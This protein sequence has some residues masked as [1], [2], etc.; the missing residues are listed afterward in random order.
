MQQR[1]FLNNIASIRKGPVPDKV[2]EK[3]EEFKAVS[4]NNFRER[5][6]QEEKMMA[7]DGGEGGATTAAAVEDTSKPTASSTYPPTAANP[8]NV[9]PLGAMPGATGAGGPATGLSMFKKL[10]NTN[11]EE[12][13]NKLKQ[14]TGGNPPPATNNPG[15]AFR[16]LPI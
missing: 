3:K 2:E 12:L 7:Q 16:R 10:R 13:I 14:T 15:A 6:L 4:V 1:A 9:R 8:Q 5:M 11:E